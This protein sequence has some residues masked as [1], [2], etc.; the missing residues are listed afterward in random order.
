MR[1]IF[2]AGKSGGG[3]DVI[4]KKKGYSLVT[5]KLTSFY[6]KKKISTAQ[7]WNGHVE[8]WKKEGK[9]KM[10]VIPQTSFHECTKK[11]K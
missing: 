5:Y 1:M 8:K 6:R 2:C 3:K 7:K 9:G 10:N 11:I 4:D